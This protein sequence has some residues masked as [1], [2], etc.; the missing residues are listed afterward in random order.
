MKTQ[1]PRKNRALTA[2]I[3]NLEALSPSLAQAQTWLKDKLFVLQGPPP[4]QVYGKGFSQGMVFA[5]FK[6]Q[7]HKRLTA[8]R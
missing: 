2:V 7:F 6:D 4:T 1:D 3:G 8:Q 5:E